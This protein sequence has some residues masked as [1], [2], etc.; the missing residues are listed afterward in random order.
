MTTRQ[1]E[2]DGL[3][4]K[5]T[6]LRAL[7]ENLRP[8]RRASVREF[9]AGFSEFIADEM[10]DEHEDADEDKREL[11][12]EYWRAMHRTLDEMLELS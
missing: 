3:L 7:A 1:Q 11:D 12:V 8:R 5:L 6:E 4:A 2:L 10:R 9:I